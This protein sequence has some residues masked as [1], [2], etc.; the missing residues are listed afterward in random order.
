MEFSIQNSTNYRIMFANKQIGNRLN[1][2]YILHL[3]NI[4]F[5]IT[6]LSNYKVYPMYRQIH[7]FFHLQ[8]IFHLF[9]KL[10]RIIFYLNYIL[11]LLNKYFH[12]IYYQSY[13]LFPLSICLHTILYQSYIFFLLNKVSIIQITCYKLV[14]Q[15]D[16]NYKLNF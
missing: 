5:S 6:M 7:I 10:K 13:T 1:Q 8:N 11:F 12:I 2:N 16:K 14:Y 4:Y 3:I 9:D 15:E